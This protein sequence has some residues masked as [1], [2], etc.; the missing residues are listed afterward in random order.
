MK[1]RIGVFLAHANNGMRLE[2]IAAAAGSSS[3]SSPEWVQQQE[4]TVLE[5]TKNMGVPAMR[6]VPYPIEG[7]RCISPLTPVSALSLLPLF[8]RLLHRYPSPRLAEQWEQQLKAR[9][10]VIIAKFCVY[11]VRPFAKDMHSLGTPIIP[12][13][14]QTHMVLQQLN[15][16]LDLIGN[17]FTD[18]ALTA[19]G[20][21]NVPDDFFRKSVWFIGRICEHV[22]EALHAAG[23][24][25]WPPPT[26]TTDVTVQKAHRQ[27]NLPTRLKN[28]TPDLQVAVSYIYPTSADGDD[29]SHSDRVKT[30]LLAI[31]SRQGGGGGGGTADGF[32]IQKIVFSKPEYKGGYE[33][34]KLIPVVISLLQVL[35]NVHDDNLAAEIR[36]V[37]DSAQLY[38]TAF[39]ESTVDLH[40]ALQETILFLDTVSMTSVSHVAVAGA[41]AVV[42]WSTI[43]S[44]FRRELATAA[45]A[46]LTFAGAKLAQV[47]QLLVHAYSQR[48]GV[49]LEFAGL[50][51]TSKNPTK[52]FWEPAWIRKYKS[53]PFDPALVTTTTTPSPP[54]LSITE[55][56]PPQ[57]Q[58]S[59]MNLAV[60]DIDV[61]EFLAA[62]DKRSP[63]TFTFDDGDG[64]GPV[65]EFF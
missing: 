35:E 53:F 12:Y 6:N 49:R 57:Q 22:N 40:L 10:E 32:V 52:A 36:T 20:Q 41:A 61:D 1:T 63:E 16:A 19:W 46:L 60:M 3:S 27:G 13:L 45:G 51:T 38:F 56:T 11:V 54:E 47:L 15:S 14:N 55:N 5:L 17:A 37:W 33:S 42:K 59:D 30:D 34:I 21:R 44:M 7:I 43:Y 2:P 25:L 23:I 18:E 58:S 8:L 39:H 62:I 31:L 26:K 65:Y 9:W 50:E 24:M 4:N 28:P 64:T 29:H 48:Y